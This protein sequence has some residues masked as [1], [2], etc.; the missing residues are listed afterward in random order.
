MPSETRELFKQ[1]ME[2]ALVCIH[3]HQN[4]IIISG[5]SSSFLSGVNG[6]KLESWIVLNRAKLFKS[7]KHNPLWCETEL[8][9]NWRLLTMILGWLN[10]E[11]WVQLT[12]NS[13]LLCFQGIDCHS[14]KIDVHSFILEQFL[15]M[16]YHKSLKCIW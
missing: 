12:C 13:K 4:I 2:A 11:I 16:H 3:S 7:F 6:C 5:R 14:P 10:S 15:T 8:M 9:F 1:E